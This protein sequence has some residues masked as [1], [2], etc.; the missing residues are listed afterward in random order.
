MADSAD[1]ESIL[2][3]YQVAL[4]LT[5]NRVA[6]LS[7]KSEEKPL[8]DVLLRD[9]GVIRICLNP[10]GWQGDFEFSLTLYPDTSLEEECCLPTSISTHLSMEL[11]DIYLDRAAKAAIEHFSTDT[12][13]EELAVYALEATA[14]R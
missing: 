14:G 12:P 3:Q 13:C 1:V 6:W 4:L 5:L 8:P 10:N 11:V 2:N 7:N 9:L